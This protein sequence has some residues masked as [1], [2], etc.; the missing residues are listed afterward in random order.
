MTIKSVMNPLVDRFG[1]KHTYLR[2]S[3]TDRCNLRC[4]YCMPAEGA[5]LHPRSTV[6]TFEEIEKLSRLFVRLGVRKIRITGGEPLVRKDVEQLC[7]SLARI[8]DLE[9]LA[10]STNG[11][12][13][14]EKAA[15]LRAAGVRDINISLDTLRPERF[16]RIALRREFDSVIGG[17]N[18]ALAAGFASVKINTVVMKGFNEDELL[19]FVAFAVRLSLNVRFIE[20]M[21]FLGN[22]WNEVKFMPFSAM[23]EI[24]ERQFRLVP[25]TAAAGVPGPAKDF[26]VDG[27]TATIGFITTMSE[28]FCGD[29]NRLRLSADGRL[30]NCLFATETFDLREA[31]RSGAP[32]EELAAVVARTLGVKWEKH[33]EADELV[34]NARE[35]MTAIGG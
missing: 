20:Y 3:V 34:R 21:P 16:E 9:N 13:L 28:H 22:G 15:A 26:A 14:A 11:V 31:L 10:L 7:A 25:R 27:S 23:R 8:P 6:L 1:R 5:E 17:I 19:D 2:I 4:R 18:A 24:I 35:V 33:P 29:C 30:R 32:D 12:A